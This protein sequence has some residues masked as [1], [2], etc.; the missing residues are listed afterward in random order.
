VSRTGA[1]WNQKAGEQEAATADH[2]DFTLRPRNYR[3]GARLLRSAAERMSPALGA[4]LLELAK[5]L[6]ELADIIER[7]RLGDG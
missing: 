4:D 7:L 5:E 6:E 1:A 2:D 3:E